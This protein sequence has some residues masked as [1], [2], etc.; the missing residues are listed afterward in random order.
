M[1][2]RLSRVFV[3]G[4]CGVVRGWLYVVGCVWLYVVGYTWL[5]A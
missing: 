2:K 3:T 5:V 1:G 4:S